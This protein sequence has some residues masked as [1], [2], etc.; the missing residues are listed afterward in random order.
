LV[1]WIRRLLAGL[2][3][4]A[5]SDAALAAD[6]YPSRPIRLV[7]G[8]GTGGV[9]DV[10]MRLAAQQMSRRLGQNIVVENRPGAGGIAAATA[11]VKA[12]PDGYTILQTGNAAAINATLFKKLPF[13]VMK[14][15]VQV[16]TV[17]VFQMALVVTPESGFASVKDVIAFAKKNPQKLDIGTINVG[18]TQY[19]AAELLKSMAGIEAQVVPFK[20][21][22]LLYTALRGNELKV[23]FELV[24]PVL[25]LIKSNHLKALAVGSDRR[26]AS[27][28]D[29]PT[30]AESG[31][32]GFEV[33]SWT[34]MSVPAGTPRA[35]VDRLSREAI[36]AVASAEVRQPLFDMAIEARGSTPE[37]AR[38]RMSS[39]IAKWR[40][41][42]ER[43][44]IEK[45]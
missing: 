40:A 23:A 35:I 30:V 42:I 17:A 29:V 36:A 41:V 28:P 45:Q 34:G 38:R 8:V 2:L 4:L 32:A 33:S 6:S 1:F 9:G 3:S 12:T 16:S 21:N 31:V 26:L 10:S 19:L 14:D 37:E 25:S 39:D 20:S 24:G 15:F 27:L 13:D 18:S 11:V 43:A 44:G 5:L 22:T 7:L